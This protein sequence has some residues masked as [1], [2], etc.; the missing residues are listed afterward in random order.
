MNT[1]K[2]SCQWRS[3]AADLGAGIEAQLLQ[4]RPELQPLRAD[5]LAAVTDGSPVRLERAIRQVCALT[6]AWTPSCGDRWPDEAGPPPYPGPGGGPREYEHW[7]EGYYR[8]QLQVVM[9]RKWWVQLLRLALRPKELPTPSQALLQTEVVEILAGCEPVLSYSLLWYDDPGSM[10]AGD[11]QELIGL[12]TE[13]F[14]EKTK[15]YRHDLVAKL[16]CAMVRVSS[17]NCYKNTWYGCP[18]NSGLGFTPIVNSWTGLVRALELLRAAGKHADM[19]PMAATTWEIGK[20]GDQLV[21]APGWMQGCEWG[22][23]LP[24]FFSPESFGGFTLGLMNLMAGCDDAGERR[25]IL[26]LIVWLQEHFHEYRPVLL[27]RDGPT[28]KGN[29]ECAHNF[30]SW[31][32]AST[33]AGYG[34]S[35]STWDIVPTDGSA[36]LP[37]YWETATKQ[38]RRVQARKL[39]LALRFAL[40]LKV[41]MRRENA[42]RFAPGGAWARLAIDRARASACKEGKILPTAE[43]G[44][45]DNTPRDPRL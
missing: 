4:P 35:C 21:R 14:N 1:E 38:R 15:V 33:S 30:A 12:V 19:A 20:G 17:Y 22:G 26:R 2:G 42:L 25:M 29:I 31:L 40:R 24:G 28:D 6:V 18:Q 5:L 11:Y 13:R 7:G 36:A 8:R 10:W 43:P 16:F 32:L 39:W 27:P 23:V 37:C 34:T 41:Y 44:S 45:L 9:P 3:L